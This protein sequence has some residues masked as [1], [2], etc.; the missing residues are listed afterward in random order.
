MMQHTKAGVTRQSVALT[1]SRLLLYARFRVVL[2]CRN[3]T[4]FELLHVLK[5]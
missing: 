5:L 1:Q 4:L 3:K 2:F